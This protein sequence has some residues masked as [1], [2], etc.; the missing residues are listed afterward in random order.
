MIVRKEMLQAVLPATTDDDSRY[1]LRAIL[2]EPDGRCLATDGHILLVA[3]DEHPEPDADFPSVD[4]AP[5]HG[6]PEKG[7]LLPTTSAQSLLKTI[8]KKSTIPILHGVQIS[9]NGEKGCTVVATDLQSINTVHVQENGKDGTFPNYKNVIPPADRPCISV[10]LS[11]QV[12]K[13]LIKS[14]EAVEPSKKL[15]TITFSIPTEEK[16]QGREPL[17]DHTFNRQSLDSELCKVC[18]EHEKTHSKP[19]GQIVDAITVKYGT[20]IKVEGV[21]MPCRI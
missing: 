9:T 8:P 12:L 10:C 15:Q 21:V 1:F 18:G 17:L 5:F 19:D 16:H 2:I 14:A 11:L 7:V 20:S 13:D 4:A 6:S 3:R